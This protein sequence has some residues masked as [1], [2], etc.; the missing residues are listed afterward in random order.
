VP[1]PEP[2]RPRPAL[3]TFPAGLMLIRDM[4]PEDWPAVRAIYQEGIA[5]GNATF[6]SSAPAWAEWDEGHIGDCRLVATEDVEILGWAALSGI[7][8]RCS[9]S[10]VAE[11]SVYVA[12]AAR[13]RSVGRR[14]L[15]HLVQASEQHGFWTLQA[16]IFPENAAS[17]AL[18]QRC[19]FRIVGTRERLG[20][21]NGRWRDVLLLERR[22]STV[23]AEPKPRCT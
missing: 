23:G 9:Y 7:S 5:T 11:V 17:V 21:M 2:G 10:G 19:G 12:A 13:G 18:H 6:Q 22:S 8:D 14:L 4:T 16:G 20:E 3:N 1:Q 15:E